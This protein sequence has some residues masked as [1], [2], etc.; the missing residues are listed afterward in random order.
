MCLYLEVVYYCGTVFLITVC[1]ERLSYIM[2]CSDVQNLNN[3]LF[4]HIWT[5]IPITMCFF[6]SGGYSFL[7]EN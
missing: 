1:I 4:V 7:L 5:V 2:E 6:I 3:G